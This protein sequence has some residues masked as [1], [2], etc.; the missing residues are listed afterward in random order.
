MKKIWALLLAVFLT[1]SLGACEE[2]EDVLLIAAD[3]LITMENLDLYM[4]RDDVQYVD[5]RNFES[6][7]KYGYIEGFEKIPFF[8]FLDNRC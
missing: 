4:F 3:S 8:D 5:L 2:K 7:F 6:T 1:I